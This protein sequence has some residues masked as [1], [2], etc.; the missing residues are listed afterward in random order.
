MWAGTNVTAEGQERFQRW[1]Q[2]HRLCRQLTVKS[3][4]KCLGKALWWDSVSPAP[5]TSQQHAE[6]PAPMQTA[7]TWEK[8]QEK[9]EG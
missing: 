3:G 8:S 7:G 9:A 1:E 4:E 2:G 6:Q 5:G